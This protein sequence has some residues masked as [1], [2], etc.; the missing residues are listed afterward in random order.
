MNFRLDKYKLSLLAVCFITALIYSVNVG[1]YL[2]FDSRPSFTHYALYQLQ[3]DPTSFQV[4]VASIFSNET[5]PLKRPLSMLSFAL[6]IAGNESVSPASLRYMN[7][8]LHCLIGVLLYFFSLEVFKYV[9]PDMSEV[10]RPVFALVAVGFWL[11]HPL[12]V[13]TVMYT[14]QRMTQLSSLLMLSGLYW[15]ISQ[16]KK[17]LNEA[18][19][20]SAIASIVVG[21]SL[22]TLLAGLAKENG[23]LLPWFIVLIEFYLFKN[24]ING[25]VNGTSRI[26]CSVLV[27][28]PIVVFFLL[29]FFSSYFTET[30]AYRPFSLTERLLTQSMVLWSYLGWL[31]FP[32]IGA[33]KFYHDTV[34][35]QKSLFNPLVL[36]SI[37]A[38][39]IVLCLALYSSV[40]KPF[41]AF[42]ILW[43]LLAHSLESTVLPLEL[44]FEHRNYFPSMGIAFLIPWLIFL[45]TRYV[46]EK[47]SYAIMIMA[48][49]GLILQLGLRANDWST[50]EKLSFS[51]V[52][53]NPDSPRA[54]Y[55]Y[56]NVFLKKAQN[57]KLKQEVINNLD[58]ARKYYVRMHEVSPLELTPLIS[59]FYI[60]S[61]Y[62]NNYQ[63]EQWLSL[64]SI[65]AEKEALNTS[66][67]NSI[68]LLVD[69]LSL[70]YGLNY[71]AEVQNFLDDIEKNHSSSRVH[72]YK[73]LFYWKIKNNP[74]LALDEVNKAIAL[75]PLDDYLLQALILS[76]ELGREDLIYAYAFTM[77][78]QDRF[79]VELGRLTGLFKRGQLGIESTIF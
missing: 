6:Q 57:S 49:I 7:I 50:E 65:A 61:R 75:D 40:K 70:G 31:I 69:V 41:I 59:L 54:N 38:W 14:V 74:R 15:Y 35:I 1:D 76:N 52:Y 62:L 20:Q 77:L 3:Q 24:K 8:F 48:A 27:V 13:S 26:L 64:M 60:D 46:D 22:W 33:M 37:V 30:Y 5:G 79:G 53:Q 4:W 23:L 66:D 67:S 55:N 72:F 2:L 32:D 56:A 29:L 68:G 9:L 51:M 18:I 45:S 11:L 47:W 44:V 63:S 10:L 36:A 19:S 43:F 17:Y 16:R 25:R 73:S 71:Q 39:V 12:Q 78:G 34:E 21:V 58:I 28:I 42:C